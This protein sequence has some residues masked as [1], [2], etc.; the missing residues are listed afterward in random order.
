MYVNIWASLVSQLVKNLPAM[1]ETPVQFLGWEDPLE[2]GQATHSSILGLPQWFRIFL[3]CRRPGLGRS[4]GGGHGNPLKYSC[5]ENPH[6]QR[7]LVGCSPWGLKESNTTE[8]LRQHTAQIFQSKLKWN[9][10]QQTNLL[11]LLL[12]KN[13]KAN[14]GFLKETGLGVVK[15]SSQ[16]SRWY[17]QGTPKENAL[18]I[19]ATLVKPSFYTFS[20]K[21]LLCFFDQLL[22]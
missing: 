18:R 12:S 21:P 2:K 16:K 13:S 11:G 1:Q 5:L 3:Q 6:G 17:V 22:K 15:L 20:I 10:P 7:S 14:N 19:C 9:Y 4:P 8:R